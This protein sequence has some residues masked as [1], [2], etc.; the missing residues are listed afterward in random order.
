MNPRVVMLTTYFRPIVGGV[1]SNAERLARYLQNGGF[2]ARV[3]TKRITR[4]LA[5]TEQ[6]DGVPH[7]SDRSAS[8][9]ERAPASGASC[10]TLRAG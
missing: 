2:A 10:P 8:A 5:D 1:E 7:R 9:S 3:L 4:A 6:M